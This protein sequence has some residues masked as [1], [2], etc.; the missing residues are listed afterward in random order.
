MLELVFGVL[1]DSHLQIGILGI[2]A[3]ANGFGV[4]AVFIIAMV[5]LL[6]RR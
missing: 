6:R 4:P 5:T 2:G 3:D 1:R